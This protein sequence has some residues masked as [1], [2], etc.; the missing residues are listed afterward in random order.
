[1]KKTLLFLVALAASGLLQAQITVTTAQLPYAGLGYVNAVDTS[2]TG[3]IPAGGVSQSWNFSTLLTQ[4]DTD[5]LGWTTA[6]STPYTSDFPS[7]NLASHSANDSIYVYFTS[8]A[9]GF[10]MNGVRYYGQ[11]AP[12]GVSKVVFNPANLYLPVPF[13]YG[14]SQSSYYRFVVDV[15]TALPYFRLIHR[16]NQT[17]NGDGWGSL[18]LPNATYPNTLRV[19]NVQT[20]YDSLLTD[21]LGLGFYIP[22]SSTASQTTN[23]YWL[24][25]QQPAMILSVIADSLGNNGVSADYFEGSAVTGIETPGN[26]TVTNVDVY[27]NPATDLV[28]VS[29]PRTGTAAS[30]FRL[31]DVAGRV[32]RE[33]MLEGIQ[34]YGFYVNHLQPG[35]YL[36]NV[37]GCSGRLMVK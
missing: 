4:D 28:T 14:S 7:S 37:E 27:P 20:T 21:V 31:T 10:Y 13:T 12:F 36:W 34:Q 16:V 15:D 25:T 1:M 3:P 24:R 29:L 33:T 11:A 22:V 30:L 32:V 18:A 17:H 9:N 35:L 6:S 26:G 5:T 23:Y 19:K 2:F 8:N